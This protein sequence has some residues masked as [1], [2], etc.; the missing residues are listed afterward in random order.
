[1][2]PERPCAPEVGGGYAGLQPLTLPHAVLQIEQPDARPVARC[3]VV[4]PGQQEVA[5]RIGLEHL[6][7]DPDPVEER[8]LWIGEVLLAALRH[9]LLHEPADDQRIGVA[10]A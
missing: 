8:A 2:P 9:R 4:V 5:V 6:T 7:P 10:I 3:S 1:M